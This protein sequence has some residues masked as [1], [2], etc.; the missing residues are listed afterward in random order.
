RIATVLSVFLLKAL[1]DLTN[2]RKAFFLCLP[3]R[4]FLSQSQKTDE[5]FDSSVFGKICSLQTNH[6]N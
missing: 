2:D 1:I 5:S 4:S 3:V 6:I